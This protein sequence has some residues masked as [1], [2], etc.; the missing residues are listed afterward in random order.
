M[1]GKTIIML[2]GLSFPGIQA[3]PSPDGSH[4]L[5]TTGK[6]D[7]RHS[8]ACGPIAATAICKYYGIPADVNEMWVLS[9]STLEKGTSMGGLQDALREKGLNTS[10]VRLSPKHL[11]RLGT[12]MAILPIS[13]HSNQLDHY[14]VVTGRNDKEIVYYNYPQKPR[15]VG[16]DKLLPLWSGQSLLVSTAPLNMKTLISKAET[17]PPALYLAFSSVLAVLALL[18]LSL[19]LKNANLAWAL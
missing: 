6:F 18:G 1:I 7:L 14:V 10:G 8:S 17:G 5:S 16:I 4:W 2:I 13:L 12:T 19:N 11:A 15:V 3:I 9:G